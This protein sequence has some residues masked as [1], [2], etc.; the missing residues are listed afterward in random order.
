MDHMSAILE[1]LTALHPKE[2]DLSLGRLLKLLGKLGN[3]H[4][5]LPPVIHVAGTNGKGSTTAYLRAILEADGRAVHS[6]TSPHLVNFRERIRLGTPGRS[7]F[8][9]DEALVDQLL[10]CEEVNGGDPITYFEITTAAA[11]LLFAEHPADVLVLE[12]GLGGRL[13]ATNV[14]EKPLVSVISSISM[15]H[16]KF[17]GDR[18]EGI[19]R[20]K[21]GIF[22][23]GVPGVTA[24]QE[25]LVRDVLEDE[26]ARLGAPLTIGG[27]DWTAWSEHG[28]MVYQD[29]D[30]LLDLPPPD[31]YGQHQF[32]N[33]GLAI[34]ALRTAGLNIPTSAIEA[35]LR[36]V[37]WPGRMHHVATGTLYDLAPIGAEIWIDGGHNPGAGQV[38]ATAMADL[39]DRV[40]RPLIMIAGMLTTKDP[41]GYFRPFEG[42]A[43]HVLTVPIT[44]SDAGHDPLELAEA[45]LRAGLTASPCESLISA[46]GQL[47]DFNAPEGLRVLIAGSLY[48]AGE[49]LATN[50]TPPE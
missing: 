17:L 34:A 26:A 33:A 31:L 4:H 15:D 43:R 40:S 35:G 47:A 18:L 1:R 29:L 23:P 8:V 37:V 10:K 9:T 21:A 12:V 20:E 44:G 28:R 41:V 6:Y 25:D 19:A 50:G 46:V 2:I 13:D 14:V 7:A 30:Q 11:F 42:L 48:L 27:Q 32:G 16:E 49:A 38:I 36:S 45:A 24:P 3:P 5:K 22:K 39:E